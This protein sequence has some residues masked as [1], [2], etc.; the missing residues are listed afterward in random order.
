MED[1]GAGV[2]MDVD[3]MGV[4]VGA[5][6]EEEGGAAAAAAATAA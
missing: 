6:V 1:M 5:V 4:L 3:I 2:D